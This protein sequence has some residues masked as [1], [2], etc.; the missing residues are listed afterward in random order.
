M[1][2]IVFHH[3][4][5]GLISIIEQQCISLYSCYNHDNC[6]Y[7]SIWSLIRNKKSMNSCRSSLS[8]HYS[9]S[10]FHTSLLSKKFNINHQSLSSHFTLLKKP[11]LQIKITNNS[12]SLV[13]LFIFLKFKKCILKT[14]FLS[15]ALNK[16]NSKRLA[17]LSFHFHSSGFLSVGHVDFFI[18]THSLIISAMTCQG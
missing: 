5:S 6:A 12:F 4:D 7:L 16:V 3:R 17:L 13:Y 14:L 2:R 1:K 9:L 15:T 11:V 10:F 8:V 18:S